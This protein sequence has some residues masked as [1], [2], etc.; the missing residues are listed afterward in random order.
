MADT[1][2]DRVKEIGKPAYDDIAE[3]VAALELDYKR[4]A[5]LRRER[6]EYTA[7]REAW[8][9]A[10]P[11]A[12]DELNRL[13]RMAGE[14]KSF[15]DAKTRIHKYRLSVQVRSAWTDAGMELEPD[16]FIILLDT[17]GPAIR[18]HGVL[19]ECGEPASA[20]L[21]VQDWYKPWTEYRAASEE[22]LLAF[23]RCFCFVE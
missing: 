11:D 19:D 9:T 22:T 17:D 8:A 21:E 10:N 20:V 5:Q 16:E 7:G 3:L 23:A 2:T 14:C 15:Y 12:A 4:L 13:E 6:D 1:A 18:I